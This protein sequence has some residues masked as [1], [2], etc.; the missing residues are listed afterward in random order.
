MCKKTFKKTIKKFED[1]PEIKID[2]F[3]MKKNSETKIH[4]FNEEAKRDIRSISKTVMAILAGIVNKEDPQFNRKTRIYP[5]IKDVIHLENKENL[6]FLKAMSVEDLLSHR[7]GYDKVLLMRQDI[8]D[9]DPYDYLDLIVNHPIPYPP[10]EHYLYSNAGYYMLSVVLQEYLVEDLLAYADRKL[11]KPLGIEDYDWEYY[12]SYPAGATRL[13]LHME[14]LLKLGEILLN[15]G[16]YAKEQFFTK[17]WFELMLEIASE[18][19]ERD[20]P[21]R[22]FRRYAYG[23]GL[24]RAKDP[25]IFFAHGTAGQTLILL[26]KEKM[27]LA[28]QARQDDVEALEAILNEAIEDIVE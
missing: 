12:G 11:F 18:T 13:W 23:H 24:W 25:N 5:I 2:A 14:D 8:Q 27:I 17:E 10:G 15:E 7:M 9:I 28:S 26:R 20:H 6:A 22:R 16:Q 19:P 4:F 21:E 3:A 1:H